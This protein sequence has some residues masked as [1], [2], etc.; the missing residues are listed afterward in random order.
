MRRRS[1]GDPCTGISAI[2]IYPMNALCNSQLEELLKFLTCGYGPGK[3]PV[4]Y[5]RYT[6]Q[7]SQ[8]ERQKIAENPP[9][10]LLTRSSSFFRLTARACAA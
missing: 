8:E 6:G 9:D 5:A 4:T 2:V 10:I 3:E 7:E 1:Q